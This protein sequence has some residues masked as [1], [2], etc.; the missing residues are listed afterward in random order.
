MLRVWV[1]MCVCH[2]L[3]FSPTTNKHL[4]LLILLDQEYK[5][6]SELQTTQ[7]VQLSPKT[8]G[9]HFCHFA[10]LVCGPYVYNRIYI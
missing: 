10:R 1:C 8:V 4:H 6:G 5:L 7:A 9:A 2:G 3:A